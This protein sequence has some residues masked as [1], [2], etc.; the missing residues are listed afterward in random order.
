[1]KKEKSIVSG[2]KIKTERIGKDEWIY[3][4]QCCDCGLV[5]LFIFMKDGKRLKIK[6]YRD[7][8]KTKKTRG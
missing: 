8:Y 4:I 6:A 5:H 3:N 7:D 1:M 2:Q